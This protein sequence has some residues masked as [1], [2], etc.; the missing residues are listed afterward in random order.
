MAARKE[1]P[2]ATPGDEDTAPKSKADAA[3]L[4][5]SQLAMKIDAVIRGG[6]PTAVRVVGEVSGFR[7]RTHWYF[8][9]KDAESVISC[10]MFASSARRAKLSPDNG[11]EVVVKGRIEFYAKQGRI[12]L[13]A[14]SIEPVGAG[15]LDLAFRKLLEEVRDLGWLDPERKRP[16]PRFPR[17]IAVVTSR[18]AA[19]L[20]DVLVT[21]KKRCP[22]VAILLADVRVQGDGAAA[23]I[24]AA[25]NELSAR[26]EELG[27]DAL[28]LTRGGGSKEDL[29]CFNER[30]VAEAIIR[31]SIP[32]V[33]AIGHETDTTL[34]ELVADERCATPTQ[35]AMRLTPDTTE[36]L[37][38]LD[39]LDRRMLVHM[40]R[41]LASHRQQVES[42]ASRPFLRDPAV[43]IEDAGVALEAA[44]YELR[45]AMARRLESLRGQLQLSAARLERFHPRA[46]YAS[47]RAALETL[48]QRLTLAITT[49]RERSADRISAAERELRAIN[50]LRVLDRGFSVTLAADG[51]AVRSAISVKPGDRLTTRVADGEIRSVAEGQGSPG[52]VPARPSPAK[53]SAN[54]PA[55]SRKD[56]GGLFERS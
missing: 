42:L 20:Q 44:Q 9:I 26:A 52:G 35:A 5:V 27:L 43:L 46:V 3:I 21:M 12:T 4:T 2:A 41:T 47:N 16:L 37:R 30:M 51:T 54:S 45:E 18:S 24:T 14:E 11:M 50:P 13:I 8:D 33:A 1:P 31:C 36:L 28:L 40:Q 49:R 15:A 23:E 7:D 22:G 19:A 6:L 38:Q 55:G 32:V 34:A 29:W 53:R 17:R 56:E 39:S 10:V 25:I 48:G